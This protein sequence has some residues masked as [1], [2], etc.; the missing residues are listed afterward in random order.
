[1][2][3]LVELKVLPVSVCVHKMYTTCLLGSQG[4]GNLR[5]VDG[6]HF[7]EG[8]VE[9]FISGRWGTVCDDDWDSNDAAVVCRQLGFSTSSKRLYNYSYYYYSST[10]SIAVGNAYFGPG[11]GVV[12]I[13]DLACVG[14]ELR[15]LQC[16]HTSSQNCDHH[17]DAGVQ[18]LLSE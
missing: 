1:M 18:C 17:R 13:S 7:W 15:L 9:V 10:D 12:V 11:S 14:S 16:A 3:E 2:S 8:R 6:R 4:N 5:L